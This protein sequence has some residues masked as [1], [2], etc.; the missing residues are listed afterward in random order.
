[1]D[2]VIVDVIVVI[3]IFAGF[4]LLMSYPSDV[5]FSSLPM[6]TMIAVLSSLS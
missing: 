1:M 3:I 6:M 5:L 4:L 2:D